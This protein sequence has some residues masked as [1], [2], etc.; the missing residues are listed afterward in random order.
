[1]SIRQQ[2]P[3]GRAETVNQRCQYVVCLQSAL[4]RLIE[5][6]VRRVVPQIA[7]AAKQTQHEAADALFRAIIE[8]LDRHRDERTLTEN[9]LQGLASAYAAASTAVPE[10]GRMG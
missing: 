7:M 5:T 1:V 4:A 8:T 3:S 6:H 10:P 9:V 2:V